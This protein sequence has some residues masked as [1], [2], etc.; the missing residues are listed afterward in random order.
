MCYTT[1]TLQVN[2]VQAEQTQLVRGGMQHIRWVRN[3]GQQW[4]F[5][6]AHGLCSR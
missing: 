6:Q 2:V 4:A 5:A 3:A 1:A